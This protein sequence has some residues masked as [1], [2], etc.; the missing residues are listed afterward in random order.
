MIRRKHT[1]LVEGDEIEV[2]KGKLKGKKGVIVDVMFR[3]DGTMVAVKFG[4]GTHNLFLNEVR[5]TK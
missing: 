2:I 1:K 5:G 3:N 4:I